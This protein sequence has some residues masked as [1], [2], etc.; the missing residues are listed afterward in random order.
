M[1]TEE[2]CIMYDVQPPPIFDRMGSHSHITFRFPYF[3]RV[4]VVDVVR[5]HKPLPEREQAI[6]NIESCFEGMNLTRNSFLCP[7]RYDRWDII[8]FRVVRPSFLPSVCPSRFRG[9]TLRAAPSKN[10]AFSANY[11]AC[12]AMPT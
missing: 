12:I 11:H 5:L 4:F 10:Y 2:F 8:C 7:T 9:T 1:L 3:V 6:G